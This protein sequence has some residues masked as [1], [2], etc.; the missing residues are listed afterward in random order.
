MDVVRELVRSVLLMLVIK[1]QCLVLSVVP[2]LKVLVLQAQVRQLCLKDD[3]LSHLRI[4]RYVYKLSFVSNFAVVEFTSDE[5]YRVPIDHD[6]FSLHP[7]SDLFIGLADT[8]VGIIATL[9]EEK[10]E[11]ARRWGVIV[12]LDLQLVDIRTSQFLLVKGQIVQRAFMWLKKVAVSVRLTIDMEFS[13]G[14]VAGRDLLKVD[15]ARTFQTPALVVWLE[16]SD[17]WVV[18]WLWIAVVSCNSKGKHQSFRVYVVRLVEIVPLT[19]HDVGIVVCLQL[20]VTDCAV[21]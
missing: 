3:L 7:L 15:P 6:E 9:C 10:D 4:D 1:D 20:N 14:T 18:D 12:T 2:N 11:G 8:R 17:A 5:P 19:H 16:D 21:E 13:I